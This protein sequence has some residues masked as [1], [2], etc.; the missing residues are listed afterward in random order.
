M[1]FWDDNNI[2]ERTRKG[3]NSSAHRGLDKIEFKSN[4]GDGDAMKGDYA[5]ALAATK[6]HFLDILHIPSGEAVRFKAYID[7]YQD[8]YDSNWTDTEVYGRMDPIYQFQGTTRVISLDWH[9]PSTSVAESLFNHK[10]CA[11]L[12]S[13][14]YPNYEESAKGMSSATQI[15]TSPVFKVKFGNLIQDPTAGAGGAVEDSGL[16]GVITGFTYAPDLDL[17][18]I[19]EGIGNLYPK[20]VKLSLEFKVLH[21]H[22]LG[23]NGT[24]K[25]ENQFPYGDATDLPTPSPSPS[26]SLDRASGGPMGMSAEEF[27]SL[28]RFETTAALAGDERNMIEIAIDYWAQKIDDVLN[29]DKR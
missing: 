9:V 23:W 19:D 16:T 27:E 2:D 20:S 11:L 13:M 25:R 21:T 22:G 8:K 15:S 29:G 24:T 5:A 18:F 3:E 4:R 26:P 7:D 1:G 12:F 17:G 6:E 10:K 14:L 28:N